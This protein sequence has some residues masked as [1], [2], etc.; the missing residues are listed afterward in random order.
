M[1]SLSAVLEELRDV[2]RQYIDEASKVDNS[3]KRPSAKAVR[4][5]AGVVTAGN[6][7]IGGAG[8]ALYDKATKDLGAKLIKNTNE[9]VDR[10][11]NRQIEQAEQKQRML[12]H[13]ADQAEYDERLANVKTPSTQYDPIA[14]GHHMYTPD[15]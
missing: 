5:G 11:T 6:L 3:L 9:R 1:I 4:I 7:A 13:R 8:V 14:P 12:K 10:T 15:E 2:E